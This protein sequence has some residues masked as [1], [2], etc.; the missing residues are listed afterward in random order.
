LARYS[1][2]VDQYQQSEKEFENAIFSFDFGSPYWTE[3]QWPVWQ[4][5]F[6]WW[7]EKSHK[8]SISIKL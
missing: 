3:I 2:E 1:Q 7:A 8:S 5:W 6:I 4:S